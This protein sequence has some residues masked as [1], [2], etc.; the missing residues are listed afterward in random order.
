MKTW[1]LHYETGKSE[2]LDARSGHI[3]YH[4]EDEADAVVS[5]LRWMKGRE[6]FPDLFGEFTYFQISP[7]VIGPIGEKGELNPSHGFRLM[8]WSRCRAGVDKET[9]CDWKVAEFSKRKD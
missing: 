6:K 2:Y 3:I 7:Y 5:G 1:S 4:A 8:E 9:Y